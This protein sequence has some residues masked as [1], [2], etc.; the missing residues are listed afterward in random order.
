MRMIWAAGLCYE[1]FRVESA[2][3]KKE[4]AKMLFL[5]KRLHTLDYVEQIRKDDHRICNSELEALQNSAS[6]MA[7]YVV[8]KQRDAK[9]A[10]E[11]HDALK[12]RIAELG[13]EA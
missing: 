4:T 11:M 9:N 2:E 5:T 6:E 3:V 1:Q 12:K 7:S 8:Q 13:G 10:L